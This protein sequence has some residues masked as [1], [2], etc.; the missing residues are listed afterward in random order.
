MTYSEAHLLSKP[1][2]CYPFGPG[3]DADSALVLSRRVVC[4]LSYG[5]PPGRTCGKHT[6]NQKPRPDKLPKSGVTAWA[7]ATPSGHALRGPDSRRFTPESLPPTRLVVPNLKTQSE[8]KH[9]L[10]T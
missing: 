9:V 1:A 4:R 10:H 3:E 2:R 8:V 7:G 5:V 6:R